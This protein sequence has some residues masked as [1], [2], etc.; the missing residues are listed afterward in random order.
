[1]SS[2]R[3][4]KRDGAAFNLSSLTPKNIIIQAVKS[5]LEGTGIIK[6]VLVF[7]VTTDK[8]NIMLSKAD[9]TSMKLEI[10]QDDITKI[11]KLLVNRIHRK[12]EEM[13]DKEV[14]SIILQLDLV[15]EEIEIF[16]QHPDNNVVKFDYKGF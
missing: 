13:S 2:W 10:E 4:R 9:N 12:F 14:K 15:H 7:D 8:Y 6:L 1:M 11:K 3:N 5:K 16:I